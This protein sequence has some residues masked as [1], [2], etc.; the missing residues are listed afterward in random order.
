MTP[1]ASSRLH[2][3]CD[4]LGIVIDPQLLALALTHRSWAFEH[5]GAPHN[6]RLEF[7]GDSVLGIVVTERLYHLF[8]GDAEG[9][10]A[11]KRASVVNTYALAGVARSLRLG[12]DV[13]LGKGEVATGGDD[14]DSI[15]ADVTEAVI[16]AVYLS[17][18][19]DAGERFVRHIMDPLIEASS[20]AGVTLDWKTEL[21]ELCAARGLGAPRYEHTAS[22]PDHDKRFEAVAVIDGARYPGVTARSKKLA[23]QGAAKLAH[24]DLVAS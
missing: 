15:L 18:G 12:S 24:A 17:A 16:A 19:R 21:Q 3:V 8:P 23:E 9:V 6:E 14:K 11:K 20:A 4:E 22:G 2:E 13:R 7:L 10:L 5:G 1:A